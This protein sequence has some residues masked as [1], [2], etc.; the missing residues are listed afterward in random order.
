MQEIPEGKKQ[1]HKSLGDD[2]ACLWGKMKHLGAQQSCGYLLGLVFRL[3]GFGVFY[4]QLFF[5]TF[6][7]IRMV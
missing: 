5:Y 7:D 3:P 6:E 2:N 1:Q 4:I